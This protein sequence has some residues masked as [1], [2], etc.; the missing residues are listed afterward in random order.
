MS[1]TSET[2]FPMLSLSFQMQHNRAISS[3]L[4][5]SSNDSRLHGN[6][7]SFKHISLDGVS[8]ISFIIGCHGLHY[9]RELKLII[10][11]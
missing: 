8:A 1:M 5:L 7:M 11:E 3:M 4:D 9:L 10:F 6:R 2:Y